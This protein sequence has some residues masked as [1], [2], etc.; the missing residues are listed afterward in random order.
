MGS[1]FARSDNSSVWPVYLLRGGPLSREEYHAEI[2]AAYLRKIESLN[3]SEDPHVYLHLLEEWKWAKEL[4][5]EEMG[6]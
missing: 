2:D 6:F 5:E 1:R 4:A 3:G